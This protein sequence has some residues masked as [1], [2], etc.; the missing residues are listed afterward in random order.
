MAQR[1]R[2]GIEQ[3]QHSAHSPSLPAAVPSRRRGTVC[4]SASSGP[5]HSNTSHPFGLWELGSGCKPHDLGKKEENG[6]FVYFFVLTGQKEVMLE[7]AGSAPSTS[8]KMCTATRPHVC[9]SL[10]PDIFGGFGIENSTCNPTLRARAL[11]VGKS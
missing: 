6:A 10:L 2:E 4:T 7:N 8:R 5:F 9:I 11:G 3:S 1:E